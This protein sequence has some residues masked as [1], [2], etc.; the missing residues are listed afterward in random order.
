MRTVATARE[1]A[2]NI[3]LV[4]SVMTDRTDLSWRGDLAG[5][6]VVSSDEGDVLIETMRSGQRARFRVTREEPPMAY[7]QRLTGTALDRSWGFTLTAVGPDR[8]RVTLEERYDF[9]NRLLL[10]LSYLYLRPRDVQKAQLKQLAERLKC[11]TE[12]SRPTVGSNETEEE[13]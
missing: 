1:L 13:C 8:T 6:Q 7:E 9:H 12:A 5:L 3:E 11:L 10:L 4:W 2:G